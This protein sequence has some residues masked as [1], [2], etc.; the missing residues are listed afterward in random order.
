MNVDLV[1]F[2]KADPDKH[3]PLMSYGSGSVGLNLQFTNYVFLFDHSP[4]AG[5]TCAGRTPVARL[6]S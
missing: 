5:C 1:N 6:G 2:C 4:R 3:E